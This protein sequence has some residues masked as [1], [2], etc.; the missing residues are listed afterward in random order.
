MGNDVLVPQPLQVWV[1]LRRLTINVNIESRNK[2]AG[3]MGLS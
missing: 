1:Q 2:T 3:D